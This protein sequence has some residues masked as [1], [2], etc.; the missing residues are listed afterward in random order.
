[1]GVE[2]LLAYIAL[3]LVLGPGTV[4]YGVLI[5][6]RRRV[7]LSRGKVLGGWEAVIAGIATMIAGIAFTYLLWYMGR[8]FPH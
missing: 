2:I 7:R 1:M 6:V 5:T 3:M 8:F 4:L